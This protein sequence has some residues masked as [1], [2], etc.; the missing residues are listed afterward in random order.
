[1]HIPSLLKGMRNKED[2]Q[3]FSWSMG[4]PTHSSLPCPLSWK[5]SRCC[6]MPVWEISSVYV[7]DKI[8]R[9]PPHLFLYLVLSSNKMGKTKRWTASY[10]NSNINSPWDLVQTRLAC[11]GLPS[12][13]NQARWLT[14]LGFEIPA[15]VSPHIQPIFMQAWAIRFINQTR[16]HVL[17]DWRRQ[18]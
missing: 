18:F 16:H 13:L 4:Q 3:W 11:L 9:S 5:C 6:A 14:P 7:D 12:R 15:W 1:V 10:S 8:G 17:F 2:H